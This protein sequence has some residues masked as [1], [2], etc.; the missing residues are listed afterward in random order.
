MANIWVPWRETNSQCVEGT[1]TFVASLLDK[2]RYLVASWA[3]SLFFQDTPAATIL[4]SW[5]QVAFTM[6]LKPQWHIRWCPPP[7]SL[8]KLKF[9]GRI[10]GNMGTAEMLGLVTTVQVR[11]S[12]PLSE[13]LTKQKRKPRKLAFLKS[14]S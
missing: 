14:P 6:I 5:Q 13:Q 3:S 10:I 12:F 2:V 7:S 1:S 4:R 9:D 11:L 8:R